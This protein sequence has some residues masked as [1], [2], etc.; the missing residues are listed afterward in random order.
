MMNKMMKIR[1]QVED[2]NVID[3]DG[4]DDEKSFVT[5]MSLTL[6]WRVACSRRLRRV[7]RKEQCELRGVF[8]MRK[9]RSLERSVTN[10][11][12]RN[13]TIGEVFDGVKIVQ[14]VESTI[15]VFLKRIVQFCSS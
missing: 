3:L 10:D 7:G 8:E 9:K 2:K 14:N 4:V 15:Y 12:C 1:F 11:R 13:G 5:R 6:A